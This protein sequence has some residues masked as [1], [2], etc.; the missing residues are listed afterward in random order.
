MHVKCL[1][2]EVQEIAKSFERVSERKKERDRQR[3]RQ[4]SE[5]E[6]DTSECV[7]H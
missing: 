3:E 6:V 4:A 5:Q 7:I 1:H 2:E